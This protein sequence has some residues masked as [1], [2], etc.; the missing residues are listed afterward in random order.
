MKL[1]T[2]LLLIFLSIFI[3]NSRIGAQVSIGDQSVPDTDA[4]LD[5]TNGNGLGLLLPHSAGNPNLNPALSAAPEGLLMYYKENFFL[6]GSG[7]TFNAITPWES[8]YTGATPSNVYFNP[9]LFEGVGIGVD[10]WLPGN[11][12]T[13]NIKANL[14]IGLKSKD[15]NTT[16]TSASLLIGD[17][18]SGVHMSMDN[19]EILVKN[20]A[21]NN[22]GTLKL[23][24]GGGTVQVGES[25]SVQSTL[26]VFGKVQESGY[27]LVPQ[28]VIVMWSGTTSD[29]PAGW[30]LCNGN[31]YN[32]TDFTDITSTPA[33]DAAHT[34]KAP[35]L[36]NRFIV[37]ASGT[38]AV[39][40]TGG[41]TVNLT[42]ANLP[43]HTHAID[44]DH[45]NA[46]T[47][48]H[49]HQFKAYDCG[50]GTNAPTYDNDNISSCSITP[51]TLNSTVNVD[52]PNF[53]GTS[54]STGS[55]TAVN[56]VPA[57]FALCYIMKL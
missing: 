28:G 4:I 29:I 52:L 16:N 24:E 33:A 37:G 54:G 3:G 44:H 40:E 8:I 47:G 26:N 57:Y 21:N 43:S 45:P 56:I 34:K 10:G 13:S 48:D 15:V 25:Q 2:I 9:A 5:L 39:E 41:G 27:A 53:T 31:F 42:T 1:I 38:Y 11:P 50:S 55:G 49:S 32:E 18:D 7:T 51:S 19:D 14:H 46:V 36:V 35:N 17:S 23:Q 30:A 12:P 6:K 20:S 22:T